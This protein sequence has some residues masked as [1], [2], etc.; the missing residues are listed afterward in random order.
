MPQFSVDAVYCTISAGF[1][2]SQRRKATRAVVRIAVGIIYWFTRRRGD[3]ENGGVLVEIVCRIGVGDGRAVGVG[4]RHAVAGGRVVGPRSRVPRFAVARCGERSA[5]AL[6]VVGVAHGIGRAPFGDDVAERIKGL[7]D[8]VAESVGD[9]DLV[10]EHVVGV[11]FRDDV[12]TVGVR[13][14]SK[15]VTGG[16]VVERLKR[17]RLPFADGTGSGGNAG[18]GVVVAD[19]GRAGCFVC[20][21][22]PIQRLTDGRRSDGGCRRFCLQAGGWV[23][24]GD[25]FGNGLR[26]V[27]V[28]APY[29]RDG[30]AAAGGGEAGELI[31]RDGYRVCLGAD[32]CG[33]LHLPPF[34]RYFGVCGVRA[35]GD[36]VKDGPDLLAEIVVEAGRRA[37]H[38]VLFNACHS[39]V[40]L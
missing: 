9:G 2:Q 8:G 40:P 7:E 19:G 33:G 15:E 32:G 37:H 1:R 20:E 30:M 35:V 23:K 4:L 11:G 25:G 13:V 36:A 6:R 29:Q 22:K 27:E 31:P 28:V 18:E 3:A 26:R 38:I 21:N 34:V 14:R 17:Q 24:G 12:R 5:A 39:K 16:G 10:A